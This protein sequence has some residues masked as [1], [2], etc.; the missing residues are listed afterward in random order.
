MTKKKQLETE[1]D[2]LERTEIVLVD[3]IAFKGKEAIAYIKG[4]EAGIKHKT[5]DNETISAILSLLE[6]FNKKVK[7]LVK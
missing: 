2:I 4:F 7:N 3:G 6:D 5:M 1:E